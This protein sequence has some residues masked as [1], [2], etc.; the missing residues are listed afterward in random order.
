MKPAQNQWTGRRETIPAV[1]PGA[2][3]TTTPPCPALLQAPGQALSTPSGWM[4]FDGNRDGR[5][6]DGGTEWACT[7]TTHTSSLVQRLVRLVQLGHRGGGGVINRGTEPSR[8][9]TAVAV[10]VGLELELA[11]ASHGLV[12]VYLDLAVA[13]RGGGGGFLA[14]AGVATQA[15]SVA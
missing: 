3:R 1:P 15:A 12:K 13:D 2:R 8:P 10:G 4:S 14:T 5:R 11:T 9:W 7:G 6:A